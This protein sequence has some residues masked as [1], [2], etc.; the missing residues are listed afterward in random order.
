MVTNYNRTGVH[1]VRVFT[2]VSFIYKYNYLTELSLLHRCVSQTLYYAF[3]SECH[4][5]DRPRHAWL[6]TF[7]SARVCSLRS[8][9]GFVAE[10]HSHGRHVILPVTC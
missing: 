9:P 7:S 5:Y 2:G 6:T 10:E 8:C 3:T 1:W 4:A